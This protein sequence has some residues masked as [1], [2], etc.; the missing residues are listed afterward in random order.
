MPMT[1][2][3]YAPSS[4][5]TAGLT[6]VCAFTHSGAG[7]VNSGKGRNVALGEDVYKNPNFSLSLWPACPWGCWYATMLFVVALSALCGE[8]AARPT[9]CIILCATRFK[10]L[11]K[12]APGVLRTQY[13]QVECAETQ[14]Q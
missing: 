11:P 1:S 4:G 6:F 7:E 9:F 2:S 5:P 14:P 13:K 12:E 8:R 10:F 3:F